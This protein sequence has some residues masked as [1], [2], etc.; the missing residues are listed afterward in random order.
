MILGFPYFHWG[1]P[2]EGVGVREEG[3]KLDLNLPYLGAV[4]GTRIP[5]PQG[6]TFY[7][8]TAVVEDAF[9][10]LRMGSRRVG[11]D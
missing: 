1:N 3:L 8:L 4:T 10:A 7:S 5:P 2:W 6:T 9:P 11:S